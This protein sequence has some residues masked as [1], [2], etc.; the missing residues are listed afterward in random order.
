M[1]NS[2]NLGSTKNFEKAISACSGDVIVLSDQDDYWYTNRL[3]VTEDAFLQ[4]PDAG[5][6]SLTPT[7]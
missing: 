2:E 1:V 5:A 4:R 6:V 3:Q 7:S